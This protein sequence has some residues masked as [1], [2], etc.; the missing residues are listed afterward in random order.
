MFGMP[1][2][3]VAKKGVRSKKKSGPVIIEEEVPNEVK[4]NS[5]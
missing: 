1:L 3:K 4:K 5:T 2:I